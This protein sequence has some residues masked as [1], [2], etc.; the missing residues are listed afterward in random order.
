M[1]YA[2]CM[3]LEFICALGGCVRCAEQQNESVKAKERQIC[4]TDEEN[5]KF[6]ISSGQLEACR[7]DTNTI[8]C[9]AGDFSLTSFI[10]ILS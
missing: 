1:L 2:L 4:L 10:F 3:S 7:R 8:F 9:H 5:W 6:F